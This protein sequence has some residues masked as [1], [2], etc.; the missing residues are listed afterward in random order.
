MAYEALSNGTKDHAEAV[1]AF[2]Q[3]RKPIFTGE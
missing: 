2:E 1:E 3:K